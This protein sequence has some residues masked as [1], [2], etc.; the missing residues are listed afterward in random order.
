MFNRLNHNHRFDSLR[1]VAALLVLWSHSFPLAGQPQFEPLARLTGFDTLGGMGVAIFFV[2]SGYL[3]ALSWDR[4]PSVIAFIR[5]RALR[6][7]PGLVVLCVFSTVVIGPVFTRLPFTEYL[8]HSM[9][10]NYWFTASAWL[11]AYPLPGVFELNPLPNV[12]NGS[13]WSLPYEVRCYLVMVLTA[14]LPFQFKHKVLGLLAAIATA[15]VCRPVDLAVFDHYWGVDHYH[16]KLG[17]LFF[18]GCALAAWKPVL[19]RDRLLVLSA[20][21]ALFAYVLAGPT[22]WLLVWAVCAC[23]I[24]VLARDATW[25]PSWPGRWGDWSYGVYLYGFPVQQAFAQ[26]GLHVYGVL[27]YSLAATVISLLLGAASWHW[28]ERPALRWKV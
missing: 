25:L 11:I 18:I 3:L 16:L 17:W 1:L 28:V 13:L 8:S 27:A 14:F 21:L 6:I 24:M 23:L 19:T 26:L 22:R 2:L 10:Q 5:N 9:T 4:K 15:V 12:V 20:T 7:Y